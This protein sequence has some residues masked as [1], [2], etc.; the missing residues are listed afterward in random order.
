MARRVIVET[1]CD[2]CLKAGSE[3]EA[4]ELPPLNVVGNKPRIMALC[5]D[6][7]VQVYDPLVEMVKEFGQ[8]VDIEPKAEPASGTKRKAQAAGSYDCP[9]CAAAGE[10]RSF[11]APQGLG[12]HRYRAHGVE[13]PAKVKAG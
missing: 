3:V 6:H 4:E 13:S 1:L 5:P 2:P 7:R 11:S 8:I 10:P 9:E 12:A